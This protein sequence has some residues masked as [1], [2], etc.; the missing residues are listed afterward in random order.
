MLRGTLLETEV[1]MLLPPEVEELLDRIDP[2]WMKC[3]VERHSDDALTLWLYGSDQLW[4]FWRAH[5][6][7]DGRWTLSPIY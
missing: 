7:L 2:G 1:T 4:S 6:S 3:G 5:L